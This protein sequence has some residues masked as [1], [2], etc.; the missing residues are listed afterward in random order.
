MKFG[1]L[2]NDNGFLSYQPEVFSQRTLL[3][4]FQTN[5]SHT[6]GI[7]MVAKP[8][9]SVM[10]LLAFLGSQQQNVVIKGIV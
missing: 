10:A 4:R 6:P 5:T 9:Y 1:L 2:S 8:A 3:A 7:H